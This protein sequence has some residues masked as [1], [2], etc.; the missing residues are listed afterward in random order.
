MSESVLNIIKPS[1]DNAINIKL[2]RKYTGKPKKTPISITHPELCKEWDHERNGDLKPE[3]FTYG[4]D[5]EVW[6]K[7]SKLD[8]CE[9]HRW[10][11]TINKR[12]R[13][14][15]TGCPFCNKG[16]TCPCINI[17]VTHPELCKEW[18]YG[19][20]GNLKPE[21]FSSGSSKKVN[22][23]CSKPGMCEH[24]CW[25]TA[26][27]HRTRLNN[28]TGCPF[29][30]M[31]RTC[32]CINITITHPELCKEWDYERN[33]NLRPENFSHGSNQKIWWKCSNKNVCEHH[34]WSTRITNRTRLNNPTGCPFCNKGRAYPCYNLII[35][36]AKLCLE[37]DC[38]R[39]ENLKPEDF[40]YQSAKE[41]YWKC[42]NP[43]ACEHHKWKTSINQRAI[44]DSGCPFCNIGRPCSCNNLIVT[45]PELCKEWDYERNGDLRPENFTS[46]SVQKV[47]WNCSNLNACEHHKWKTSIRQ[48]ARL[49]SKCPFCNSGK[50]CPCNNLTITHP[51]LCLEWDYER[52]GDLIP[53]NFICGSGQKVYWKCHK[54]ENHF[55]ITEIRYR[56]ENNIGCRKCLDCPSCGLWRTYGKLCEYCQP[57]IQNKLYY[58]TKEMDVV[59]FLRENLDEDFIHNKS[60]GSEC[61][62]CHLF[63]D[64]RFECG[65]HNV[66]VEVDEFQHRGADYECDKQRMYNIIAKLGVPCIFI[67]YNP[68]NKK[69]DKNVLLEKIR[70]YLD[71]EF[72]ENN[73][74]WDDYGFLCEYLYYQ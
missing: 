29:C 68:D 73:Y 42:L 50:A 44:S 25:S 54:N 45:H 15:P 17:T 41:V 36:H 7:C 55:W 59:N 19:K 16:R 28:P 56:T 74:I 18:D 47:N 21:N 10:L 63:P 43:N 40:T 58:K 60:V 20:N 51:K 33:E 12:T 72:K 71:I 34:K 66:I 35:T 48:R 39:N 65:F 4:S 49:N 14:K 57:L 9:H 61:T 69:S 27:S 5:Q 30:N 37:W 67:R 52:N 53:E 31:G 8:V 3:H 70:Y 2:K 1:Y 13:S 46:G 6:W 62:D 64:I 32:S 22:W 38:E 24:H 11:A 26:I 23:K